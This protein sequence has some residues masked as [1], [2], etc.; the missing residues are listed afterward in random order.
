MFG[1]A[2]F[3]PGATK[4]TLRHRWCADR[5][6][7][8]RA[9]AMVDG[10][11]SSV[12]WTVQRA[13]PTFESRAWCST[14]GRPC[15]GCANLCGIHAD[16]AT[17]RQLLR[18]RP[19][20]RRRVRRA[21]VRRY[22]RPALGSQCAGLD[23]RVVAGE[24]ECPASSGRPSRRWPTKPATSS[25]P[26]RRQIDLSQ[27]EGR[28]GRV[29]Q[30]LLCQL[31]ADLSGLQIVRPQELERTALGVAYLAGPASGCGT[32]RPTWKRRGKPTG[33]SIRIMAPDR[34]A[35]AVRGW[36]QALAR[37]A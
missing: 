31:I 26:C 37:T 33:S 29:E 8:R 23:H 27:P 21:R 18:E 28:R 20:L 32:A 15:S 9:P 24:R 11:T 25:T 30:R 10:L 13:R 36:R 7:R 3:E 19:G 35:R 12:A 16:P 5:Q 1:Q 34:R 22:L 6:Q 14:A 17:H 2:C 4:N